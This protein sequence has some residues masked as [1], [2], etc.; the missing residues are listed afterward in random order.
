MNPVENPAPAQTRSLYLVQ[1]TPRAPLARRLQHRAGLPHVAEQRIAPVDAVFNREPGFR[2]VGHRH[3]LLDQTRHRVDALGRDTRHGAAVDQ[4]RRPLVAQAGAGGGA[5]AGQTVWRHFARLQPQALTQTL[6]QHGGA[7]HAVG[8]VVGEQHPVCAHR[9]GVQEAVEA[10]RAFHG[11]TG[12]AQPV[13][14]GGQDFGRQPAAQVL[15]LVQD[16]Q[17]AMGSTVMPVQYGRDLRVVVVGDVQTGPPLQ[18][19]HV[20]THAH[21]CCELLCPD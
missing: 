21:A 20:Q 19:K 7:Q 4:Q 5:H 12:Q 8:D 14:H 16:L 15:H 17:Q 1:H 13:G 11:H 6:H 3:T 18:A 2:P 10:R 9:L